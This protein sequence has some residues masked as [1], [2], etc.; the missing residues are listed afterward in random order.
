M[1]QINKAEFTSGVSCLANEDAGSVRDFRTSMDRSQRASITAVQP[2]SPPKVAILLGTYHGQQFLADQLDSFAAQTHGNWQVW[3]SDDASQDDTHAML[4]SYQSA[5]GEDRFSISSGPSS[6]FAANFLALICN[7]AIQADYFAYSDQDDIWEADKLSRA[8]AWIQ[9][10]PEEVPALYCS[11]TRLVDDKNQ[12]LGLSPLFSRPPSFA[13]ALVQNIGGGNTM[14]FNRAARSLLCEAGPHIE[15]VSHDWW[16]YLLVSGCGGK[17]YYDPVPSLRY[18]Q[19]QQN[20]VGHNSGLLTKWKRVRMLLHGRYRNWNDI[21]IRALQPMY[22]KLTSENQKI[23]DRFS[24]TRHSWAIPRLL[25]LRKS[26]VY[27]QSPLD[28]VALAIATLL[29]KA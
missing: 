16:T 2:S 14:V 17:V 13:N 12:E 7:P 8:L 9:N 3:A 21:N 15:I 23:Y 29:G 22:A 24:V 26:G 4:S 28:N 27:R 11:R 10:I 1:N 25:G 20:L 19:H 5:W 18:R 6:G